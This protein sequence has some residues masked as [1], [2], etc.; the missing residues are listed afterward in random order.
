MALLLSPV[1]ESSFHAA[2]GCQ[3]SRLQSP[4]PQCDAHLAFFWISQSQPRTLDIFQISIP[5]FLIHLTPAPTLLLASYLHYHVGPWLRAILA[6][7]KV[8]GSMESDRDGLLIRGRQVADDRFYTLG[9]VQGVLW[10]LSDLW[11]KQGLSGLFWYGH[12]PL[13][14]PSNSSPLLAP[15]QVTVSLC[16]PP[17]QSG[18]TGPN[19]AVVLDST[20]LLPLIH[21]PH[22]SQ[23]SSCLSPNP[24]SITR[25][26]CQIL[27]SSEVL[28]FGHLLSLL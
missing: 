19:G 3:A 5:Q 10:T 27:P 2:R 25:Y 15:L 6:G 24:G 9:H 1:L 14:P 4:Q 17:T 7:W 26:P 18:T 13:L 12:I 21:T 23:S 16:Y 28:A 20:F 11:R 8:G 22:F